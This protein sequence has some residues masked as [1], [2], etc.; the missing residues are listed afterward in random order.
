MCNVYFRGRELKAICPPTPSLFFTPL[1]PPPPLHLSFNKFTQFDPVSSFLVPPPG[2]PP[3]WAVILSDHPP[4]LLPFLNISHIMSDISGTGW[5]D[6][7]NKGFPPHFMTFLSVTV[8]YFCYNFNFNNFGQIRKFILYF[9][10]TFILMVLVEF[11][12]RKL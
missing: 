3:S 11:E 1:L 9:V 6:F 12:L 7:I 5:G 10:T 8:F 2:P 4:H